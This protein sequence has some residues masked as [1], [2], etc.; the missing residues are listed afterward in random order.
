[1]RVNAKTLPAI[2]AYAREGRVV[3]FDTETRIAGLSMESLPWDR[4]MPEK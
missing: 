3:F 2:A 1:M 4:D